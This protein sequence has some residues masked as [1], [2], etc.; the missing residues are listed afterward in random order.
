MDMHSSGLISRA[1][2]PTNPYT[3]HTLGPLQFTYPSN[4]SNSFS[5]GSTR[6]SRILPFLRTIGVETVLFKS[7]EPTEVYLCLGEEPFALGYP[8]LPL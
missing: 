8:A 7:F 5:T 1:S 6:T 3:A 4:P 2:D